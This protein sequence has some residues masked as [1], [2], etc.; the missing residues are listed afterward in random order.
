MS[1]YTRQQLEFWLKTI[2]VKADRVLDIGGAQNPI[3]GRT[4][5]WEVGNYLIMDLV[6][7]HEVKQEPDIRADIQGDI[8]G[9][10]DNKVELFDMAF[11]IEV[12]EYWW[13]PFRA[14][15]NIAKMLKRNGILY[16]SSHFIYPVHNPVEFDYL[17]YTRQGIIKLLNET[18]FKILEIRPRLS[19][20]N[21]LMAYYQS[22]A[23]RPAK[24]YVG[25]EEVGHLIKAIK[26]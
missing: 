2:D 12:L 7:P 13:N 21:D 10:E 24:G 16:V 15:G 8:I 22:Q 19:T 25:H 23:M 14:F 1:S 5:S 3:K 26:L 17:R 9:F 6:S 4:K 20:D 18:G 11:C